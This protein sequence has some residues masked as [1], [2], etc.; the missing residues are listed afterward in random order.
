MVRPSLKTHN[1][2]IKLDLLLMIVK[3]SYAQTHCLCIQQT[4]EL[5]WFCSVLFCKHVLLSGFRGWNF[6][7]MWVDRHY[8]QKPVNLGETFC[9]LELKACILVGVSD[10][11]SQAGVDIDWLVYKDMFKL[12][13]RCII[14]S[15]GGFLLSWLQKN[16][17]FLNCVE[18][19]LVSQVSLFKCCGWVFC[20]FGFLFW[21]FLAT[22]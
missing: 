9:W 5:T 7:I 8:S 22:P 4:T 15:S 19:Y 21:F 20:L 12:F 3:G 18:I 11:L 2:S 16:T 17:P 14:M 1:K 10:W 6:S 13:T